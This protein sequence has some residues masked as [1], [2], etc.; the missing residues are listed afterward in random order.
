MPN[1]FLYILTVLFQT[2]QISLST[3]FKYE[4]QFYFMLFSL[5]NKVKSFQVLLCITNYSIKH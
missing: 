5:V 2:I 4:K 3:Q 1:P